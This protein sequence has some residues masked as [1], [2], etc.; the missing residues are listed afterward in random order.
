M[1]RG[2]FCRISVQAGICGIL[3][4]APSVAIFSVPA[5]SATPAAPQSDA[6]K[7]VSFLGYRA[8]VPASWQVVDLRATPAACVRFDLHAVYLG[9]PGSAERCPAHL[10]AAKTEALLVEP[11]GPLS[12]ASSTVADTV[13][14][15]YLLTHPPA[16]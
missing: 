13:A 14:H 9:A 7:N 8:L 5:F 6:M 11:L 2:S 15:Q 3:L 10:I 12:P 1:S 16:A 4:T